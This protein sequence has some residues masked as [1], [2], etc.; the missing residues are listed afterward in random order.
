MIF[1]QMFIVSIGVIYNLYMFHNVALLL[2][3]L[4]MDIIIIIII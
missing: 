4:F 2:N 3:L 1:N